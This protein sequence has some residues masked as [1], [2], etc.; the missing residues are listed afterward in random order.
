LKLDI[1]GNEIHCLRD[2][3]PPDL[4]RYVS[5]EKTPKSDEVMK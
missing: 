4:P 1:E 3:A 2:L 5:F